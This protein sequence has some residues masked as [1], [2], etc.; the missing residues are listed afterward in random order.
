MKKKE[1]ENAAENNKFHTIF[2]SYTTF[3]YITL[4][5]FFVFYFFFSFFFII[6]CLMKST[7]AVHSKITDF[8]GLVSLLRGS[9]AIISLLMFLLFVSFSALNAYYYSLLLCSCSLFISLCIITTDREMKE[10]KINV[11]RKNNHSL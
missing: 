5:S 8:V 2:C 3:P 10:E 11:Q 9:F 7:T 1:Q 6:Y 4:T